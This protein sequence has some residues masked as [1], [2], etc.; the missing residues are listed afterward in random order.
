MG[1]STLKERCTNQLLI[2]EEIHTKTKETKITNSYNRNGTCISMMKKHYMNLTYASSCNILQPRSRRDVGF[3][4]TVITL[5]FEFVFYSL[6]L[7][8]VRAFIINRLS[9]MKYS[10]Y[11][12]YIFSYTPLFLHILEH[13]NYLLFISLFTLCSKFPNSM[14]LDE[15]TR[16][17]WNTCIFCICWQLKETYEIGTVR[18]LGQGQNCTRA[19]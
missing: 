16:Y 11:S 9:A 14:N 12:I 7:L 4:Q 3:V 13:L 6:Y 18:L 15:M 1:A 8:V 2:C 5:Y 17:A 19:L 10:M